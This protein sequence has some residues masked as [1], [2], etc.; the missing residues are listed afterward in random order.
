[1][2]RNSRSEEPRARLF[3]ALEPSDEDRAALAEWRDRAVAG[4]DDLR[5]SPAATLHL[6]LAFLGYRPVAEIPAVARAA[7]AAV[8][9]LP[10]ALLHPGDVVSI[11]RRGA[12]RL[13]ALDL[14]DDG[15]RG[16]AIQRAA[17]AALHRGGVWEP[18]K[19]PWWP[20]LTLAR[21]RPSGRAAPLIAR[22][23]PPDPVRAP[24]VTLYRS[25]LHPRG[26]RYEPLERIE[27]KYG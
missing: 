21:V 4:R 6:T 10:P 18:E 19:R 11:P 14:G 5:P 25:T 1:V 17:G 9:D 13:F 16:A 27:L 15:G 22:R 12:P 24:L 7:L 3:V 23:P 26:A 20:H 8:A 2:A